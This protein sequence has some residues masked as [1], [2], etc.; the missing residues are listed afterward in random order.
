MQNKDYF[1]EFSWVM[2]VL[3]SCENEEQIGTTSKLF[4]LYVKKWKNEINYREI[5]IFNE[6]FENGLKRKSLVR[7]NKKEGFLSK[8]SQFF[9]L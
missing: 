7:K 1:C 2:K 4:Q 3:D 6:H 5:K 8:F 9:L